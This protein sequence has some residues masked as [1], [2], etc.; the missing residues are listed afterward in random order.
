MEKSNTE[1][2]ALASQLESRMNEG[3]ST[4]TAIAKQLGI[5]QSYLSQLLAGDKAFTGMDNQV[6][7]VIANFL[8]IPPVICFLLAGKLQNTDFI[9]PGVE[10][11]DQ[12]KRALGVIAESPYALEAAV[13]AKELTE[14][15]ESVKLFLVLLYQAATGSELIS[16]K[17]R[18]PW[19]A[20]MPESVSIHHVR[21]N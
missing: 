15:P 11:N 5:S 16:P 10:L 12:V 3:G 14:L 9:D 21:K 20:D 4:V 13:N 18:W 6:L 7:R 17:K 2:R 19:I 8:G 1:G